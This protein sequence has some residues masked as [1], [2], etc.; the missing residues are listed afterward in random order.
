MADDRYVVLSGGGEEPNSAERGNGPISRGLKIWRQTNYNV[1]LIL[2]IVAF[3]GLSESLAFG[4]ALASYLYLSTGESNLRV[5]FLESIIGISKL[6]TA[7]PVGDL[8][9]R[10]G[11]SPIGK[12]GSFAYTAGSVMT[13][14]AIVTRAAD[15]GGGADPQSI[16]VLWAVAMGLWGFGKGVVD[17]PVLALFA[18]S[19]PTGDRARYYYYL[20]LVFWFGALAGPACAIAIFL[21]QSND[22]TFTEL[23][24]V[25]LVGVG[26]KMCNAV[27]LLFLRDSEALGAAADHAE[28]AN[29]DEA[30]VE[31]TEIKENSS[32]FHDEDA[33]VAKA[34]AF[35]S[36]GAK[37][38]AAA[39]KRRQAMIPRLVFAASLVSN[40]GAGMTVKY[41]P[42]FFMVDCGFSPAAVQGIYLGVPLCML[43]AGSLGERLQPKIGR[44]Q[45]IVAF[46][47]RLLMC[48]IRW[49]SVTTRNN[50]NFCS[51]S[52]RGGGGNGWF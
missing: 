25:L 11:R 5:G 27:L 26:F 4:S 52:G 24:T 39:A 22:W 1:R 42:L 2:I 20:F 46:K 3:A 44:V 15:S 47:V 29:P 19:V 32:A 43:L 9:D 8:S 38:V 13:V 37:Q 34:E 45:T 6:L 21:S 31:A 41:F 40:M 28:A 50:V 48:L 18:D 16:F 7:L 17:G 23:A 14:Y 35:L 10:F 51:Q 30:E 36:G 49:I 12:V 33:A